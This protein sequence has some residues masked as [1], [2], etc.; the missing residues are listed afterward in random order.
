M[1]ATRAVL[2]ILVGSCVRACCLAVFG[3]F[4]FPRVSRFATAHR[5]GMDHWA[6]VGGR[7]THRAGLDGCALDSWD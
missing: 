3:V 1:C 4:G 7:S 2:T 6:P 5:Y